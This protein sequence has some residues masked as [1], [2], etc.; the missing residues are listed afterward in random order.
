MHEL[1]AWLKHTTVWLVLAAAVFVGVQ[2]WEK[3][4]QATRFSVGEGGGTL[5]LQRGPDG[6]YHWPG[7]M[8]GRKVDFLI[9][10]GATSTAIP[11]ELARELNLSEA[12]SVR[13]STA[14]GLVRGSLVHGD[15]ALDGGVRIDRLRMTALPQLDAP[16][17]GMDVLGKLRWQQ[18][19]G[20]LRIQL[21]DRPG[22]GDAGPD[23]RR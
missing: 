20:V 17:L 21:G 1:P 14:G 16:L 2:A 8:N 10:T 19:Q 5:E 23:S 22:A 12:G 3:N 9:D 13:S 18:T 7:R 4:A 11:S 6:H 15:L